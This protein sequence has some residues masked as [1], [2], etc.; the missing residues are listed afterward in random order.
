MSKILIA[1][2]QADLR[3]MIQLGLSLSG[4]QVFAAPDGDVALQAAAD[5][6]PDLI[7]MDAQMP[8]PGSRAL[9]AQL[10]GLHNT[11]ILLISGMADSAEIQAALQAGA[12]EYLRKPFE[13]HDLL[14]RVKALLEEA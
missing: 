4:H 12:R 5:F 8:G 9:C 13:L 11:P 10:Q 6:S 2:D 1:D 14:E 3:E 7:I